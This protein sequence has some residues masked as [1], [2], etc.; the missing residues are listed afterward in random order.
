MSA[1]PPL[2]AVEAAAK[3]LDEAKCICPKGVNQY[4]NWYSPSPL[5]PRCGDSTAKARVALR[6]A[7]PHFAGPYTEQETTK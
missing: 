2:A 7:L 6:A 3:A 5:C 1:D 4:G